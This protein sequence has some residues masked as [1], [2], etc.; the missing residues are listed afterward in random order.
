[1]TSSYVISRN[2]PPGKQYITPASPASAAVDLTAVEAEIAETQSSVD[3]LVIDVEGLDGSV[4]TLEADMSSLDSRLDTAESNIS[5][6]GTTLA[7]HTSTLASQAT[8]LSSHTSSLTSLQGTAIPTLQGADITLGNGI[9]DLDTR[10]DSIEE[11]LETLEGGGVELYQISHTFNFNDPEVAVSS[12]SVNLDFGS[13]LPANAV[14]IS[15]F[16][17]WSPW[18]DGAG[19][20]VDVSVGIEGSETLILQKDLS[21]GDFSSDTAHY[22]IGGSQIKVGFSADVN[23]NTLTT[24]SLVLKVLYGIVTAG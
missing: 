24:G 13:A 11:Q 19:A 12:N 2:R 7:S 1:V 5:S 10:V 6:H 21:T 14:T 15:V 16:S 23:L 4:E 18:N 8:T 17:Q 3:T 9:A 22:P 20:N